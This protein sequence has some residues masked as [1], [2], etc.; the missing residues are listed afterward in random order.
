[1]VCYWEFVWNRALVYLGCVLVEELFIDL[2]I[3]GLGGEKLICCPS[4][5]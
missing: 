1:M 2:D 4:I 5:Y 3:F